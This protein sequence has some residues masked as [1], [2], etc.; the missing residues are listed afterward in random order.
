MAHSGLAQGPAESADSTLF[1]WQCARWALGWPPMTDQCD[2]AVPA[3]SVIIPTYNREK[4]IGQAVGSVLVQRFTDFELIVIDD[5]ST[6][7][8]AAIVGGFADP[9]VT[10]VRLKRNSGSNAARNAGI[11]AAR[12]PLL[13]FLDSDDLFMPGK[14]EHV[15]K[16]FAADPSLEVLVDSSVRVAS[17]RAK[18]RFKENRNPVTRSTEEFALA[19][20]GKHLF[21]ATSAISVTREAAVRAGLFAEE[22]K[23][24]QDFDF[25]IRLTETARCAS[26]DE[27]LWIKRWTHDRI[28]NRERF[29]AAT[30]E[31][32][33]RHP[34]YLA[35]GK[36]RSGLASDIVRN[37]YL[38][39]RDGQRQEAIADLKLTAR[40]LGVATTALLL[41]SGAR[42]GIAAMIRRRPRK[43]AVAVF[44]A[45]AKAALEAARSRG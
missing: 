40:E 20:F 37:C 16:A 25:L 41:A 19:L 13:C 8:T 45:D 24:R 35:N 6:D 14:L 30:L 42:Q 5:R 18:I 23:Q 29:V 44:S 21:K 7:D 2:R 26:T 10:L 22:V 33:R 15:A 9:R 36:Y 11:R 34:Q 12:A 43:P 17:P 31:L 39:F 3:I 32:V 27:M 38:L 1:L 4:L 28:T